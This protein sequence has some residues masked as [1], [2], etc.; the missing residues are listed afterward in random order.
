M[1]P[2]RFRLSRVS[3]TT[4]GEIMPRSIEGTKK[5]AVVSSRIR[6]ISVVWSWRGADQV[7]QG[8]NGQGADARKKEQPPQGCRAGIAV[9]EGPADPGAD[10]DPGKDDAD[11][12]CPRV[13]GDPHVGR[14]D[15]SRYE[16][17]DERAETGDE[18]NNV[19]LDDNR[20]HKYLMK[21]AMRL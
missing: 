1:F 20:I 17:D 8:R 21:L 11:D 9:R 16:L 19:R 15:P 5:M 13:Q 6:N 18:N 7:G 4:T 12:A 2:V 10:A 14:H 3:F